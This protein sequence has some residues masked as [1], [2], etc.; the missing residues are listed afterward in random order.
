MAKADKGTKKTRADKPRNYELL[1]GVMRFSRA[2]MFQKRGIYKKKPFPVLK[3]DKPKREQYK[4]KKVGG[5][6]N[7]GERKVLIKKNTPL[8]TPERIR[9]RPKS[10]KMLFS[11]HKRSL[12]KTLTPG[13]VVIILA[14]RHKGKRAVFLKQL[15]TGLLLI[16]GPF[17]LNAC[18]LRRIN[19]IYVIATKT[20]LD[21]SKVKVPESLDDKY[22]KRAKK[23][24]KATKAG[25]TDIFS[26]KK[27]GYVLSDQRKKDQQDVDAQILSVVKAHPDK[28]YL[29][30]YLGSS[31]SL[32]KNEYPHKLI[33]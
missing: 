9:P 25:E 24:K 12:R 20:K 3:K 29:F 17:K 6:K 8:L 7:G 22:F 18:P 2:R 5:E 16:T 30:G 19:Q 28:K 14:G 32:R 21:M 11:Q 1:P 10:R 23:A 4:I 13:T 33:F 15:D 26:S 27:E 31:W